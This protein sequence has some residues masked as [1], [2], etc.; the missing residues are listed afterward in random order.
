MFKTH[1]VSQEQPE[2]GDAKSNEEGSFSDSPLHSSVSLSC[3]IYQ[4]KLWVKSCQD[5]N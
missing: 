5:A 2:G 1:R 3:S 4:Q